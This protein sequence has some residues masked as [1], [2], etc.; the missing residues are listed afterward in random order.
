MNL[1]LVALLLQSAVVLPARTS[2]EN[3]GIV[4]PA[5]KKVQKDVDKL[6]TRFLT[7]KA[8]D[9]V[10]A[11]VDKVLKKDKDLVSVLMIRFYVHHYAGRM[12]EAERDLQGVLQLRPGDRFSLF[13]LAE[14]AYA[15][16]DFARAGDLY[17]RL[18]ALEP[19]PDLETKYQKTILLAMQDLLEAARRASEENR[20]VDAE[21]YY[22]RALRMAPQEAS[23]HGQLGAILL[24]QKKWELAIEE[25]R[26]QIEL[27]GFA[28]EAERGIAE[29]L[30][31]LGRS[32]SAGTGSQGLQGVTPALQPDH[33]AELEELGRWG[34]ER[35][36]FREIASSPSLSREQF[37]WILVRYFPEIVEFNQ[38]P[39]IVLDVQ[40][41]WART[42]VQTVMGLGILDPMPNHTFQPSRILTLGDLATAMARLTRLLGVSPGD[43]PRNLAPGAAPENDPHQDLRKMGGLGLLPSGDAANRDIAAM[44]SGG[45]AVN[46][47]EKLLRLIPPRTN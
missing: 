45:E 29:A 44:V 17:G 30:T 5:P 22:R 8:D 23:L 24:R 9:K 28:G 20:F 39:Q 43:A 40:S 25:F 42:E 16:N 12:A 11:D 3:P 15:R 33:V 37:A 13:Y 32:P 1:L 4:F 34:N 41:S 2:L 6:W 10:L 35:N 31:N 21:N 47:A 7:G 19:R 36:R 18:L 38:N 27:G 14:T 26:R 46:I